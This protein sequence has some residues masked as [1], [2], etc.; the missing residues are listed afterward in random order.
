MKLNLAQ[1]VGLITGLLLSAITFTGCTGLL[2]RISAPPSPHLL[3]GKPSNAT[4]FNA[5]DY[6]IV[7]SQ[8]ALSSNRDKGIPN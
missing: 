6:L 5:N 8:Y 4:S 1:M 2:S 7:R 3:L